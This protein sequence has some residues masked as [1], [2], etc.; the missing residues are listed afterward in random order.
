MDNTG[1]TDWYVFLIPVETLTRQ[2]AAHVEALFA[3]RGERS[4]YSLDELST[5]PNKAFMSSG[6]LEHIMASLDT[7]GEKRREIQDK[8]HLN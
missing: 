8:I 6:S 7:L 5:H 4:E 1:K 3:E 2:D